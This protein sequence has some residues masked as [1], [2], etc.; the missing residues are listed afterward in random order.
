MSGPVHSTSINSL[1]E[2]IRRIE[3]PRSHGVLPFG[4]AAI[5]RALPGGGLP[6]GALHEVLDAEADEEDGAASAGFIAGILAR[7]GLEGR[8]AAGKAG[9]GSGARAVV[10]ETARSVWTGVAGARIGPDPGRAGDGAARRGGAVGCRGSVARR[11]GSGS[12]GARDG[13]TVVLG[14]TNDREWQRVARE[15]IE[16]PD[17]VD[18]P[19]FGTNTDR[20][21][22]RDELNAA[23]ETWCAQHDLADIQRPPTPPE[24]ATRGTTCPARSSRTRS[25]RPVTAGVRSTPPTVRS[26]RCCRPR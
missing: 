15:I 16:R 22:R 25:C 1:R 20:C 6:L 10:P 4:I 9:P 13:Q 2:R 14:T 21:N 18:D 23:I 11:S 3:A 19:R 17:L 12:G 24:S 7:L 8:G 5:D 26:R